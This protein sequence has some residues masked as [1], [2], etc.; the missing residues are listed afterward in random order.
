MSQQRTPPLSTDELRRYGRQLSLAEIGERGQR[1][2]KRGSV[3]VVGAGGLGSPAALYLAA[4]G[5]GRLGIADDDAV[6][7]SNLHRQLLHGTA[8]VGRAKTD[9]ARDRLAAVNPHVAVETFSERVTAANVRDL[10]GA[11]DVVIDGTDNFAAR[12]VINDACVRLGKP[13]VYGSVHRF[14]GQASVFAVAGAPCYRCLHRAPPPPGLVPSCA[15]AG[16]LGVLPGLIGVIQATEALKLIAGAGESLAG[17]LLLLNAL[18]MEVRTIEVVPDPS[19]PACGDAAAGGAARE[20]AQS[21]RPPKIGT[22][23][24]ALPDDPSIEP[25]ELAARLAH[26]DAIVVIDVREPWE[27]AI[28]RLPRARLLPLATLERDGGRAAGDAPADGEIVVYCHHGVRSARAAAM[29][30]A[31]GHRR[32]LNLSGGIDRWSMDVDPGVPRY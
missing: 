23:D 31:A 13:Y 4:A 21:C 6:D 14:E 27:H 5:I 29:L 17:R 30:R 2:L 11:F 16:V 3:L 25:V 19:C 18:R 12:Y 24:E 22:V 15:E 26:G 10:V 9:S 7:L 32:V 28:A 1:R 8:D 20:Y